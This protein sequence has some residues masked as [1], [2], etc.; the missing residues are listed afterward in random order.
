MELLAEDF[1]QALAQE[2]STKRFFDE[3]RQALRQ[4]PQDRI[5]EGLATGFAV[6]ADGVLRWETP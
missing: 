3:I 5:V 1:R 2:K 6:Q 4:T